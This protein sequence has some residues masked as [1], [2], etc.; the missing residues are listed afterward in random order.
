VDPT[1]HWG[2]PSF[3]SVFSAV[4]RVVT[5]PVRTFQ[6]VSS[7]A[8]QAFNYVSSGRAWNDVKAGT[9]KIVKK[10]KHVAKKVA[11][12]A[13]KAW[14]VVKDTTVRWVKKKANAV[15]DAYH[16]AKKCLNGGVKK[17]VKETAK[18]A[19]KKAVATVKNTVEAIKKD[20][21][22]FVA[23][24]AVGIAAAVAVGAL[25]ATGIG[26]LLVAGAVAGAMSAGAG[27]MVDV[28]RGDQDFSWSGLAGT[29]I[30]GGLDGAL[31][32]GVS[33]FTGGATRALGG[34]AK[35]TGG[36]AASRLSGLAARGG[37]S[38]GRS[39]SAAPP[40]RSA[41]RPAQGRSGGP[42]CPTPTHSFAPETRVLLADGS[43][44]PIGDVTLGDKVAATDPE[45]GATEA[46]QVTLLH[47]NE[48]RDLTD[49][50]VKDTDTGDTTVLKTTQN[51][52]FWDATDREW[53]DAS[54]LKTGHRLL[55]HDDK[56]QEGDD[57]GAGSGGGGPGADIEVVKVVNYSG[58]KIM[59][60]I[61]VADIHTYHVLAGNEPVLVHNN[62]QCRTA[63]GQYA[64]DP[65]AGPQAHNRDTEYPSGYR[66]S[67]HRAMEDQW[68]DEGSGSGL[69]RDQL[70]WRDPSGNIVPSDQLTYE[71]RMPVVE[72]WNTGGNN[73]S[74]AERNDFYNDTG[75]L[76]P[77]T[78]S[79]NSSGGAL[80]GMTYRQDAGPN[81]SR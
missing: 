23:T 67:T 62:N 13:K 58:S 2:M 37:S 40:A 52:P 24:A 5:Q 46:K 41:E 59:R 54:K 34:A 78:R 20:P 16:S 60:D 50:T 25:C 32:A 72:H 36:A 14:K 10:V 81:Y 21:W 26:C 22:K 19:V 42:G 12:K 56:R 79:K 8:S 44:K 68:T 38:A 75:N 39:R 28:S 74:R 45:T 69:S 4:S 15:K 7:Y 73:M 55:P 29:M 64:R 48:D 65:N 49:V 47:I 53:V 9:K 61:T 27:Y 35:A 71:H 51:H 66:E 70:T 31:S 80:L 57:S 11:S 77:M 63:A 30:E 3:K 76:E 17:C 6:A 1:G 18:K 33:R 43:T